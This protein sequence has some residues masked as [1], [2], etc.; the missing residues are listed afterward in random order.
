[1]KQE[2]VEYIKLW[3]KYYSYAVAFGIPMPVN[4]EI[5]IP[6]ENDKI[7]SPESLEGIYYVSKAYLEVMWDMEFYNKK[8]EINIFSIFDEL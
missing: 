3:D 6:Y 7:L 4:K 5:P 8:S 1:M 2:N